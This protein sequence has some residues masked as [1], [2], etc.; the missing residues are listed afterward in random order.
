MLN[1]VS[2]SA[3]FSRVAVALGCARG[4]GTG[5]APRDLAVAPDNQYAE[6][7]PSE[8]KDNYTGLTSE[9]PGPNFATG[10]LYFQD[11]NERTGV[12][13]VR[14]VRTRACKLP[15]RRTTLAFALGLAFLP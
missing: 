8:I 11:A 13:Q 14:E 10:T 7:A 6:I 15:T 1:R 3:L 5:E 9:R 4:G 12:G 2:T